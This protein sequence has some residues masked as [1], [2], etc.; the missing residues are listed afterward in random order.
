MNNQ[1]YLIGFMG[2]GKSTVGP[3]I[4]QKLDYQWVDLDTYIESTEQMTIKD[5]FTQ[6]GEPYFRELET[7][8]LKNLS[9]KNNIVISTGGGIVVTPQNIDFLQKEK[10]IYLRWDF[11][12]LYE[13]I[14]H[15]L[16]RPLVKTYQQLLELYNTRQ[17]LYEKAATYSLFCEGKNRDVIL[18][19]IM[20]WIGVSNEN[21]SH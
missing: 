20:E 3:L 2:S 11:D 8:H 13:R 16:N 14:A 15:D 7:T 4:A 5:L 19:E 6:Y 17:S 12:T 18:K 9:Q 10:T 1:I 21:R